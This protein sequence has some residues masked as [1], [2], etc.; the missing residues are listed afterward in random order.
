MPLN[1]NAINNRSGNEIDLEERFESI[2]WRAYFS[3]GVQFHI[4]EPVMFVELGYTQ[5]LT[6]LTNISIQ[7]IAL[8]NKLKSNSIQLSTGILFSL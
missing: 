6:N 3:V 8:N 1:I 7:E 5:S 2:I 4:G